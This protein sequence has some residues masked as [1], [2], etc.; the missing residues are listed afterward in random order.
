MDLN[1]ASM[2]HTIRRKRIYHKGEMIMP[3][4]LTTTV[5]KIITTLPNSVNA[6]IIDE[7]Y[8]YMRSKYWYF[9]TSSK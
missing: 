3:Q 2:Y 8:Q 9:R 5:N 7:F 6:S 4:K 1:I